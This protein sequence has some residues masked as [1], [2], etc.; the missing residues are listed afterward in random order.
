[1][2]NVDGVLVKYS[3][4]FDLLALGRDIAWRREMAEQQSALSKVLFDQREV[5]CACPICNHAESEVYVEVF[6]YPYFKCA[7]CKH[8]YLSTPVSDGAVA[9]LYDGK[10]DNQSAQAKIYLAPGIFEKD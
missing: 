10:S 9:S 8:I 3:K 5:L 4:S 6:S 2:V 1:M 7:N